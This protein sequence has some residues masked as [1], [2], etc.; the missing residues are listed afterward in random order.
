MFERYRVGLG[1]CLTCAREVSLASAAIPLGG[2]F[3][4]FSLRENEIEGVGSTSAVR[5]GSRRLSIFCRGCL[6]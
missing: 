4:F 3:F 5:S 6:C 2:V 1:F